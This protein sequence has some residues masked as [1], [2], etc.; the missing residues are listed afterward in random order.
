MT[1]TKVSIDVRVITGARIPVCR[2]C[3]SADAKQTLSE[4]YHEPVSSRRGVR[5]IYE[6]RDNPGACYTLATAEQRADW[7][8]K[9]S[10]APAAQEKSRCLCCGRIES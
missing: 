2:E 7:K 9:N 4:N 3:W 10:D 6:D 8:E 5:T 1:T